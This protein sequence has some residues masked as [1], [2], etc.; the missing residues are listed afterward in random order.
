MTVIAVNS[1][2]DI[3]EA[4]LKLI[5][6]ENEYFTTVKKVTRSGL[7]AFVGYDLPALNYWPGRVSNERLYGHD[8]RSFPLYVEYYW[9]TLD[10][11][12]SDVCGELAS[13]VITAL[14]RSLTAP[15]V[16]DDQS[17]D[18]GGLVSD[19]MFDS[20]DYQIGTGQDPW[21]GILM[22]FTVKYTTEINDMTSFSA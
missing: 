11:P 5:S 12:F 22:N 21:C 16:S 17:L 4:R 15:K 14:N 10:R 13:D 19:F 18:L 7:K 3:I 9:K 2:L 6:T 1:I 8:N 20:Y